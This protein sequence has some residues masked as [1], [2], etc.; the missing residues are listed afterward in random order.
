MENEVNKIRSAVDIFSGAGG[1]SIGAVMTGI[2]PVLAVEYDKY[3]AD[4]YRT[5]HKNTK[6]L[7]CD[8]KTV[9]PLEHT[10]KYPSILS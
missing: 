8:I 5:N 9:N 4:T 1:M 2:Q 6:V 10:E 7:P 3:A